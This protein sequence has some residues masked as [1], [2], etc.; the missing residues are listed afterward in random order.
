MELLEELS[1]R[2]VE[3]ELRVNRQLKDKGLALLGHPNSS[4]SCDF[5]KDSRPLKSGAGDRD[6]KLVDFSVLQDVPLKQKG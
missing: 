6:V 4:M 1:A 2:L 3:G 5:L